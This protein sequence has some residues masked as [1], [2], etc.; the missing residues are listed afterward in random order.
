MQ[1][2]QDKASLQK[3]LNEFM[4][5]QEEWSGYY[6]RD[7]GGLKW[8]YTGDAD[9]RCFEVY[10][11]GTN[12]H[13]HITDASA[14]RFHMRY[15]RTIE[16]FKQQFN[17][18]WGIQ[19][20]EEQDQVITVNKYTQAAY[21]ALKENHEQ[22]C[23]MFERTKVDGV[24]VKEANLQEQLDGFTSNIPRLVTLITKWFHDRNIIEGSTSKDQFHKLIQ[25]CGELSDN[26]CKGNCIKDDIGDIFVVLVG[27]CEMQGLTLED[28][29]NVA[30][31]DIK[32]RKGKMI[33]GV[34][35][36]ETDLNQ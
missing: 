13:Y 2:E 21:K 34:F 30:Y 33:D 17:E 5:E 32:D 26:L 27:L 36:K 29:I 7:L 4:S 35:V 31:N 14:L 24:F 28:C 22:F 20:N 3:Q 1:T 23:K 12:I 8:V 9:T 16:Q 19:D 6:C 11:T 15:S 10:V 18:D 25:E